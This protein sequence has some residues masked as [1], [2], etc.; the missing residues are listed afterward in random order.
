[1]RASG[2][3]MPVS[4]A[5]GAFCV[6]VRWAVKRPCILLISLPRQIDLLA[7]HIHRPYWL[8]RQSL[9]E[10]FPPLPETLLYRFPSAGGR[11]LSDFL[12]KRFPPL[13]AR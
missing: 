3:L 8:W 13:R 5:A 9:P 6:S 11:W 1:M 2:I 10:L 7:D 4:A 12:P